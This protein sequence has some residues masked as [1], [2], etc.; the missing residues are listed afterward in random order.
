MK[1]QL[2]LTNNQQITLLLKIISSC[3]IIVL[4]VFNLIPC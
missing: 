1:N 4:I 2:E 3:L